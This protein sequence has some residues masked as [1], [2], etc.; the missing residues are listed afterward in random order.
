MPATE[1]TNTFELYPT[2]PS[3]DRHGSVLDVMIM[4]EAVG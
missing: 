2:T 4:L 1:A 3:L